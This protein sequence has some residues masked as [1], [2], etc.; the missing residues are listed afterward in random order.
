[1]TG[2]GPQL[3]GPPVV[4]PPNQQQQQQQPSRSRSHSLT[5]PRHHHQHQLNNK[6]PPGLEPPPPAP[7]SPAGVPATVRGAQVVRGSERSVSSEVAAQL[8]RRASASAVINNSDQFV[9]GNKIDISYCSLV[10]SPKQV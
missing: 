9:I 8:T 3:T 2:G 7:G 1:M 6:K 10:I 5:F 4:P